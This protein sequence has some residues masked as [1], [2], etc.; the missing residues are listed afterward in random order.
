M[1]EYPPL[2]E[3]ELR[4]L[5]AQPG[6]NPDDLGQLSWFEQCTLISLITDRQLCDPDLP[7]NKPL[8]DYASETLLR[9]D[10]NISRA[11]WII[12]ATGTNDDGVPYTDFQTPGGTFRET[13]YSD[14]TKRL[15][16]LDIDE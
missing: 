6:I 14:G 15:M 11:D 9:T 8:L 16:R 7:Q 12:M 2:T 4:L 3:N 10:G 13:V 1:H 5:L